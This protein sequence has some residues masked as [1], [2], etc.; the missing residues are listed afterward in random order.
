M[1]YDVKNSA[2]SKA[3]EKEKYQI[4]TRTGERITLDKETVTKYLANGQQIT[5]SEFSMFFSLCKA[6]KVNPFL[7]EA[8]IIKYGTTPATIV[9]DYKVLQQVAETKPEYEGM[10]HG[11]VVLKEDGSIEERNGEYLLPKE[12]IVSGWCEVFR[13]DRKVSTKVYSMFE[14]FK[15]FKKD[16]ELNSNWSTKPCFMIV[17]V[18]KAQALREAFPNMFG[19]NVYISEEVDPNAE[20]QKTTDFCGVNEEKATV[21]DAS[22]GEVDPSNFMG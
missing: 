19:S 15:Q 8:Y 11:L 22:T 4:T 5:D 20:T 6:N 7:R 18:A 16:G 21:I 13:K 3:P 2:S 14:E 17:K 12:K 10:K 1:A 9:L